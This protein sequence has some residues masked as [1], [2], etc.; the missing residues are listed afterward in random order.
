MKYM[1][2]NYISI[3][4]NTSDCTPVQLQFRQMEGSYTVQTNGLHDHMLIHSMQKS[5]SNFSVEGAIACF[6]YKFATM[7]VLNLLCFKGV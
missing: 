2:Q 5:V 6:W 4:Q 7:S 3:L 1:Y